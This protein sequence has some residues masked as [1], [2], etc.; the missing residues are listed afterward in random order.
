MT[1]PTRVKEAIARL[2]AVFLEVPGTQ[3][4]PAQAIML[5]GLD[6]PMGESVLL[7]LEQAEFVWRDRKGLYRWRPSEAA[8]SGGSSRPRMVDVQP[9]P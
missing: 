2:R 6:E 5:A 4:S 7:A 8:L 9:V 3:L 1:R